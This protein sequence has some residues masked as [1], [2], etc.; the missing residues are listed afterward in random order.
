[1]VNILKTINIDADKIPKQFTTESLK[2]LTMDDAR[3]IIDTIKDP[4]TLK[5]IKY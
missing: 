3:K 5:S 2:Q 1:M 4:N